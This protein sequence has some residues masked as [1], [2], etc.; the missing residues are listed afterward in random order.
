MGGVDLLGEACHPHAE[1]EGAL[2]GGMDY[3]VRLLLNATHLVA[4]VDANQD[5]L[6]GIPNG[7]IFNC[8]A[9]LFRPLR[10]I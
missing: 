8:L 2:W 1:T 6:W 4:G 7:G 9:A 3:F 5:Y 10:N